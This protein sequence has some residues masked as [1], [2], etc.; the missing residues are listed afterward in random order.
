MIY[1]DRLIND[2]TRR[3]YKASGYSDE[4]LEGLV[5]KHLPK[6]SDAVDNND[7]LPPYHPHFPLEDEKAIRAAV[8]RLED[9]IF[10]HD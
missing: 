4:Y 8:R 5:R 7:E 6:I 10:D 2:N 9:Y 1:V 3:A